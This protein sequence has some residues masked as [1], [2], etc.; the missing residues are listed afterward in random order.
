VTVHKKWINF[1]RL[2]YCEDQLW[3]LSQLLEL[4]KQLFRSADAYSSRPKNAFM[5]EI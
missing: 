4:L 5:D 1:I 3:N 2:I